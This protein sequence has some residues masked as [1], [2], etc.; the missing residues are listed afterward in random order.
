MLSAIVIAVMVFATATTGGIFK[1]GD[2]Y[3]S[4]RKP[5]WTPP[6]WAFPV[7][8]TILYCMIGYSGWLVWQQ[9]GLGIAMAVW[10][11]QLVLNAAWSWIFFGLKRMDIAFIDVCFMWAAIVVYIIA[12]WPVSPTAS[13]LFVPYLVWTTIAATLNRV[14]WQMN[15]D[16]ARG[17]ATG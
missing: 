5:I 7:V 14:V 4:L 17:P 13:L 16:Q 6:S 12:A 11:L 8:W 3:L 9:Q 15:L 10:T 2:W 1:P